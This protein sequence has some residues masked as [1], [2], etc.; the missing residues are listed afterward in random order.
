MRAV[1][2]LDRRITKGRNKNYTEE[3]KRDAVARSKMI[4]PTKA[5]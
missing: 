5:C 2:T 4:G 3:F 1:I